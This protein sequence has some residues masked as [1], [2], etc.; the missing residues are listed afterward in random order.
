MTRYNSE[1][2]ASFPWIVSTG[3]LRI[4]DL[5]VRYWQT[6]EQLGAELCTVLPALQQLVGEDSRESDWDDEMACGC[7]LQLGGILQDL[8]PNGFFFGAS[9][10]DGACFG[11]WL[12]DDWC[13]VMEVLG[14]QNDDPTGWASLIAELD[15]DGIDP[16]NFQ[17]SYQG[18]TEGIDENRAGAEYAQRLAEEMN[19]CF[20]LD[21]TGSIPWPHRHVDWVAAWEE[22]R[23]G[24]GYWLHS[25]GGG[26]WLV[27]RAV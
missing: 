3:T 6:A 7:L 5:L 4:E 22:L 8:A 15:N 24:D 26:D 23:I 18:N 17:D 9:E 27:F 11:F 1:Q 16:E 13:E 12:T 25:I 20:D 21:R 10:G 14:F 2:L 19:P